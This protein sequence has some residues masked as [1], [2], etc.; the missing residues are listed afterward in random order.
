M[1]DHRIVVLPGDGV[2]PEVADAACAVLDAVSRVFDHRFH[3]ERHSIGWAAVREGHPVL[4]ADTLAACL[5]ADGVFLGA[6]GHPDADHLP[7]ARRPEAGLLAL[8][9]ELGLFANLRPARLPTALLD[10]SP[11]RPEV[12]TGTDLL[13]VRELG[14]G[15]Y[16]GRPRGVSADGH[17][18]VN[19]MVY[20][21]DEIRR[22][23]QVAFE[24]ARGRRGHVTSI[25]KA[26]VLEVSQLWRSVIA[27]VAGEFPDVTWTSMLVDRAAM[28]LVQRPGHWDVWLTPN[29]FGDILSDEA[30]AVVGS[31]GLLGSA[32]LGS[33][34]GLFEPVH[35]S[36][37]D[38][39]GTDTANPLGAIASMGMLLRHACD[40]A[41]EADAVD[42]AVAAV[43]D[44][45]R[46]TP[47]LAPLGTEAVG[48]RAMAQA[49]ADAVLTLGPTGRITSAPAVSEEVV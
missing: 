18:A 25:D 15:I 12:V 42:A 32:S 20:T 47:D 31:I 34:P 23:A 3:V 26:N 2:G 10:R 1:A 48:T 7:P 30:G 43:L 17:R 5:G 44:A 21:A 8:R 14:G 11:L 36:A 38:I 41:A 45:G 39:A 37:P 13:I 49:V 9:R 22:V 27:D 24:A 33:G 29:M 6:V 28:E 40:L 46:R 19:T 35:G 4:P 16:Y